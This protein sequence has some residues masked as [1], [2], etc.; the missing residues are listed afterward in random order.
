MPQ[1]PLFYCTHVALPF[2]GSITI[3]TSMYSWSFS[4]APAY[5][6]LLKNSWRSVETKRK[7]K[8]AKNI[9]N[10]QYKTEECN[11]HLSPALHIFMLLTCRQR[12]I[13]T[14]QPLL[15]TPRAQNSR[16]SRLARG[17]PGT[18]DY[19]YSDWPTHE[20]KPEAKWQVIQFYHL[21]MKWSNFVIT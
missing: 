3:W 7:F 5:S 1:I 16:L 6:N 8:Y 12:V 15:V 11:L 17:A 19:A 20:A 9:Y 14:R 13:I 4:S 21:E 2:H 10:L 18:A